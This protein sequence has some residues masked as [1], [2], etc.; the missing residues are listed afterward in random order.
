MANLTRFDPFTVNALDPFDDVFKG[1]FRPVSAERSAVLKIDVQEHDD[2]YT[3]HAD[4]P[5]VKKEDIHVTID[6]NRV[7]IS[8]ESRREQDVKEGGRLLRSERHYGKLSRSFELA[9]ELD[10]SRA[11]AQYRDGVLQLTLPKKAATSAR[12]L[13]IN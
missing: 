5:G 10:D 7:V 6:G 4:L 8:A 9:N 11:D 1:F 3:V 12:K 2:H 13:T